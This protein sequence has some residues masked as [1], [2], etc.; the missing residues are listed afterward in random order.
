MTGTQDIIPEDIMPGDVQMEPECS[1]A[2]YEEARQTFM[3]AAQAYHAASE[4]YLQALQAYREVIHHGT[5][6]GE[7]RVKRE[8][9]EA[10][11]Q[12][13]DAALKVVQAELK[14]AKAQGK[15][16]HKLGR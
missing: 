7:R 2:E 10:K 6:S 13:R 12:A 16:L 14:I 3:N 5:T 15:A 11:E 1:I 8:V 9:L 4:E